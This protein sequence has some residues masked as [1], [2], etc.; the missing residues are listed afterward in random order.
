MGRYCQ[1]YNVPFEYNGIEQKWGTIKQEYLK[2][3]ESEFVAVNCLFRFRNL[4]DE[5]VAVHSPND[6]VLKLIKKIKPN[7]FTRAISGS[8]NVPF[9]VTRFREIMFHYSFMFDMSDT[10]LSREDSMR[11]MFEI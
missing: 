9:F 1:R 6:T 3:R 10:V 2:L 4:L 11:V 8:H 7:V 5:T